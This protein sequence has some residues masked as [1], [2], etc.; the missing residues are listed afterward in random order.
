MGLSFRLVD[1]GAAARL[2]EDVGFD[3][4]SAGDHVMFHGPTPNAF[5]VLA[6]VSGITSRVRLLTGIA[7]APLYPAAL[8]AKLGAMLDVV[9]DGRLDFG[10]GV[11][12]EYPREFE[13]CGVPLNERGARTNEALE[14]LRLLWSSETPVTFTGRFTVITEGR[15]DPAPVQRP[16]PPIWVGGRKLAA[17]RRAARYGDVWMPYMYTPEMLRDSIGTVRELAEEY[18]RES[19]SIRAMINCFIAVNKNG[20]RARKLARDWVSRVY[21]QDFTGHRARY[22]IA[23]SP[24]E[25]VEQLSEYVEAGASGAVFSLASGPDENMELIRTVGEQV[26][27]AVRE[28]YRPSTST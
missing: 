12:G 8:L 24:D 17:M 26:L 28:R 4:I 6:H 7:L 10:V 9:S 3:A 11:G 18:E 13:A 22:L 16:C 25:C 5:V 14:V 23:G 2:I 1:L 19:T 27:P 15:I 20:D 21:Q